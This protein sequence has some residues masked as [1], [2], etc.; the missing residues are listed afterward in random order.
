MYVLA[1]LLLV[2][3]GVG[4]GL[5]V[6]KDSGKLDR[7]ARPRAATRRL[8]SV[9]PPAIR[10]T[11]GFTCAPDKNGVP[12]PGHFRFIT[13]G[14]EDARSLIAQFPLQQGT[15]QGKTVWYVVT[16]SSNKADASPAT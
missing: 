7:T 15:S 5:I 13:S 14:C 6:N 16:D 12:G 10:A 2:A 8:A 1:A 9:T 3:I 11:A 4:V